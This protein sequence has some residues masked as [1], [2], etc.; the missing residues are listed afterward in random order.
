MGAVIRATRQVP[1]EYTTWA[2]PDRDRPLKV[3]CYHIL[4]DPIHVLDAIADGKYD[5]GFK[6]TY[7]EKAALFDSM[8]EVARFGEQCRDRVR[9]AGGDLKRADL[10]RPID[11]YAGTTDGNE[12]FYLVLSHS[13]HHLRQLYD[14]LRRIGVEPAAPLGA[15]DFRGIPMPESLW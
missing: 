9:R 1:A 15:D 14:M 3:F 8:E 7:N 2:T 5:G 12:L 4:V 13:A 11:G 10:D 6:L